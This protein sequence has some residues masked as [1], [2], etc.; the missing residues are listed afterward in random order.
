MFFG[1]LNKY[2]FK[3]VRTYCMFIGYPRSGHS[4]VGA[5]IDAHPN[6]LIGMETD[7][8][9]LMEKGYSYDQILYLI[10]KKSVHFT[11]VHNNYWTGYSYKVPMTYQG[12]YQDILV[13]GD[14]QGG[15]SSI[16][17]ANNPGLMSIFF[18]RI[19]HPVKFYHIVRNTFDNITTMYKRHQHNGMNLDKNLLEQKINAY[20]NKADINQRLLRN[21]ELSILTVFHENLI[22]NPREEILKIFSFIDLDIDQKFLENCTS[23]IYKEPHLSRYEIPWP[24]DLKNSVKKRIAGYT[25]LKDYEF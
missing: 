15:R 13:I 19:K 14:K 21:K 17:I 3:K 10:Y 11:K 20:F 22:E 4:L 18:S 8:L 16:R 7:V 1:Q 23:I 2:R 9:G 12:R 6:A 5:L 24:E 25:F